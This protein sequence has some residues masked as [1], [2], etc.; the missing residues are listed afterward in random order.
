M[1]IIFLKYYV[2]GVMVG[3]HDVEIQDVSYVYLLHDYRIV[4]ISRTS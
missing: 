4:L 2:N 1:K 3:D